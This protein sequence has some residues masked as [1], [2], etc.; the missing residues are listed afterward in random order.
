MPDRDPRKKD[1]KPVNKTT[2]SYWKTQTSLPEVDPRDQVEF[3]KLD[4][5]SDGAVVQELIARAV[6][7]ATQQ[8]NYQPTKDLL[9]YGFDEVDAEGKAEIV[10]WMA[11]TRSYDEMPPGALRYVLMLGFTPIVGGFQAGQDVIRDIVN[12]QVSGWTALDLASIPLE[13]LPIMGGLL[14]MIRHADDF[15]D[16]GKAWR[17]VDKLRDEGLSGG[18][19]L[20][21][22][23][24]E[25][26][27][28]DQARRMVGL[29]EEDE[30][31]FIMAHGGEE[32]QDVVIGAAPKRV[33]EPD[34][35]SK[36]R[37]KNPEQFD[38]ILVET[39][40]ASEAHLISPNGTAYKMLDDEML[41]DEALQ[42]VGMSYTGGRGN[43]PQYP[44][45]YV[46]QFL[47]AG[48]I[49]QAE[50]GT[51]ELGY[52]RPTSQQRKTLE[53]LA[54]E[55]DAHPSMDRVIIDG[56]GA[57][58]ATGRVVAPRSMLAAV[59]EVSGLNN[60]PEPLVRKAAPIEKPPPP[61]PPR[62]VEEPEAP[63]VTAED[64]EY[65]RLEREA[66]QA[67]EEPEPPRVER[68]TGAQPAQQPYRDAYD[69][70]GQEGL[71]LMNEGSD[72][73]MT[74]KR[75]EEIEAGQR[76]RSS[77]VKY[78]DVALA[79]QYRA[80]R[81]TQTTPEE[82]VK[83]L[84]KAEEL[85]PRVKDF[86]SPRTLEDWQEEVRNGAKLFLNE[87]GEAGGAV[88]GDGD[89]VNAFNFGD[90]AT[91]RGVVS[92]TL[93]PLLIKNGATH[94]DWFDS[95]L[96]KLYEPYFD[97]GERMHFDPQYVAEGATP[98][99]ADAYST[100]RASKTNPEGEYADVLVGHVKPEARQQAGLE[101]LGES[102]AADRAVH[103]RRV[104]D[105]RSREALGF[106]PA[107]VMDIT[108]GISKKFYLGEKETS[109][110]R[111]ANLRKYL[112]DR[113][114]LDADSPLRGVWNHYVDQL[115]AASRARM[116]DASITD[117]TAALIQYSRSLPPETLA[118]ITAAGHRGRG[119][120]EAAA[121]SLA[122]MFGEDA[123][124]VGALIAAL[125]PNVGVPAN[126][127]MAMD[128]WVEWVKAGRPTD[129]DAIQSLFSTVR[130]NK[131]EDTFRPSFAARKA[132]GGKGAH[133][134]VSNAE[135]EVV[136]VLSQADP[137][138]Y[139]SDMARQ[140]GLKVEKV[141]DTRIDPLA[142]PKTSPFFAN[143]LGELSRFTND[144]HMNRLNDMKT[145]SL[146]GRE[147][148]TA[149][150]ND[151]A[152]V[153]NTHLG[154]D[155]GVVLD[156]ANMQEIPW[157]V[158]RELGE[159]V[160]QRYGVEDLLFPEGGELDYRVMEEAQQRAAGAEDIAELMVEPETAENLRKIGVEPEEA[161]EFRRTGME[162]PEQAAGMEDFWRSNPEYLRRMARRMD[163][164]Y[165]GDNLMSAGGL[166]AGGL[167]AGAARQSGVLAP[168]TEED[169][170]LLRGRGLLSVNDSG[171]SRTGNPSR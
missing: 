30:A 119:W 79:P 159:M 143:L 117:Q 106:D 149:A 45:G 169:P 83:A 114:L 141:G 52:T 131:G 93:I 165:R 36:L 37:D 74:L 71:D 43:S 99:K 57:P 84:E 72:N 46:N 42:L 65:E 6:A 122:T 92:E 23:E 135:N 134:V 12:D 142:G 120:Y 150:F 55:V 1:K 20:K 48:G 87:T 168:S 127:R 167:A 108:G 115:D 47:Q 100:T 105:Y 39:P 123:P 109:M 144:T 170:A 29:G 33:R 80:R 130:Y 81:F 67:P 15:K 41:H 126:N 151:A 58:Y 21:R 11:S 22:L 2:R 104:T 102:W 124:Q 5:E 62:K 125:S 78:E 118:A 4:W 77:D 27:E 19:L 146:T 107:E 14:G 153:L 113:G 32:M 8:R 158:G 16:I 103:E 138:E 59:D 163:M 145:N 28:P 152:N 44:A 162:T 112:E 76:N 61:L 132:E 129:A 64:L 24:T 94:A 171:S 86:H 137:V 63:T 91:S 88:L 73:P 147:V 157:G 38:E 133:G 111:K 49:R 96:T 160:G 56:P 98:V 128:L 9:D 85:N 116:A 161:A 40:L 31:A 7:K 26:M 51:I 156:V 136:R 18:E 69:A 68:R 13:F 82:F 70:L 60:L 66:M 35:M 75:L 50:M 34:F 110:G 101:P 154:I 164:H 95:R 121:K 17:Y 155:N 53:G 54:E 10:K 25:G 3:D 148:Q 166:L 97:V 139:Y 90:P 140:Q 89:M